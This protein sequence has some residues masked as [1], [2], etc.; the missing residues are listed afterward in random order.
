MGGGIDLVDW[1]DSGT[2]SVDELEQLLETVGLRL[3][4]HELD[5]MVREIDLDGNGEIDFE[6]F[7]QTMQRK[8]QVEYPPEEIAKS[9]KAFAH[10]APE[11]MIRVQDLSNALKTYMHRELVES[12]VD[13]LIL[14][15]K[16]CFVKVPGS[17]QEYFNYQ[18]YIDLMSPI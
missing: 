9:F 10:N 11:G 7:C 15:Y 1:D 6:E 12:E 14:H 18:D 5:A 4:A 16:D 8:I 17:D 2:I 13:E 3:E